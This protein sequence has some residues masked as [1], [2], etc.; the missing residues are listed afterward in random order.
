[1]I[2][3]GKIQLGESLCPTKPIQ[4]LANQKQWI[5]VFDDYIIEIPIIHAKAETFIW[6]SIEEDKCS[7]EGFGRLNKA[8]SQ[9]DFDVSFQGFQVYWP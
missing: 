5:L 7:S 4:Q 9:V 3:I 6:L 1:M 8:V 2:G